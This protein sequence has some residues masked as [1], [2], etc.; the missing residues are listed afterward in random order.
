MTVSKKTA[1][2]GTARP[3]GAAEAEFEYAAEQAAKGYEQ[4]ATMT[5]EGLEQVSAA[6]ING[7]EGV[8]EFNKELTEAFQASSNELTRTVEE[9]TR[10]MTD[11]AKTSLEDSM[12]AANRMFGAKSV[13]DFMNVQADWARTSFERFAAES[14][15]M[16]E[17]SA[18]AAS[19]AVAPLNAGAT[20]AFEK[21][22]KP[23]AR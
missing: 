1:G 11:Y 15:K 3:A 21:F 9:T 19:A 5:R 13:Q 4:V 16:Q 8:A 6:A 20:A 17:R 18:Q 10:A 23:L 2:K 22:S 7:Y 12:S 14:A